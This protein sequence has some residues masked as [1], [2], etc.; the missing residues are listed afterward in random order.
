MFTSMFQ[1]IVFG[2]MEVKYA[3]LKKGST[4]NID[5]EFLED[6]K[7]EPMKAH[8]IYYT[9]S[10][11]NL[12]AYSI[13]N[14]KN[15]VEEVGNYRV[16]VDKL[17][18]EAV[19]IGV[20]YTQVWRTIVNGYPYK[21]P[22]QIGV[23]TREEAC[24]V[25]QQ[26]IYC[27]ML[28]RSITSYRGTTDK[29]KAIVNAIEKLYLIGRD[30]E[31]NPEEVRLCINK[32]GDFE[33]EG[34]YYYQTYTVTAE[35]SVRQYEVKIESEDKGE[36][37][38]ADNSG[39]AKTKFTINEDFRIMIPKTQIDKKIELNMTINAN[40]KY[41]PIFYGVTTVKDT[42][43]YA[44]TY[45][46]YGDFL[47]EEK[48][49]VNLNTGE[50]QIQR[51]SEETKEPIEGVIFELL[52]EN[53]ESVDIAI[54]D[55]KGM[56][57]F[58][59][60]CPGNYCVREIAAGAGIILNPDKIPITIEYDTITMKTITNVYQKGSLKVIKT[61]AET[62][63][64][65]ANAS[66]DLLDI[67]GNVVQ[68]GKT[69][70]QGEILFQDLPVGKYQLKEKQCNKDYIV[71]TEAINV[72]IK[73]NQTTI[74]ET[75]SE[76]KKGNLQIQKVDKENHKIPLSNVAFELYSKELE[77]VIGTYTTDKEGKIYIEN[78]RIG[79]YKLREITTKE[80][81]EIGENMNISIQAEKTTN[82][83]VESKKIPQES[84]T[85]P[86]EEESTV[87]P[88][89]ETPSLPEKGEQPVPPEKEESPSSP[90]KGEP[91]NTPKKEVEAPKKLPKTGF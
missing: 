11:G 86:K 19:Q 46:A 45:E 74:Q 25:T 83:T 55:E 85:P 80:G 61:D 47:K 40:C 24:F 49:T 60:L 7:W 84:Q 36:I 35:V 73:Y 64:P 39:E 29:G 91:S 20:N 30:G 63:K 72:E 16:D 76:K 32:K 34:E 26:A 62:T 79:D 56:A 54:T 81:Y 22:K 23:D 3:N 77:K 8:Y 28:N 52:N 38:V 59:N 27:I 6:G 66:L 10:K 51:I 37:F 48:L 75:Q 90:E 17:L 71:K 78:L 57:F 14:G 50:L 67:D 41:Y 82:I 42:Q 89:E 53:N 9:S 13:G 44:L 12:P 2:A 70:E 65:I 15:G 33:K 88:E 5:V 68:T 87:P 21:T 43:D 58:K 4:S 31:Q 69:N 18:L 1:S